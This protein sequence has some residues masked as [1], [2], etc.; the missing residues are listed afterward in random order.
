MGGGPK[1]MKSI[2]A[3]IHNVNYHFTVCF[4]DSIMQVRPTQTLSSP[5]VL[6]TGGRTSEGEPIAAKFQLWSLEIAATRRESLYGRI[7][8]RRGINY[9]LILIG[10]KSIISEYFQFAF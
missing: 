8:Q 9:H 3:L 1:Q 4:R 7:L 6:R 2:A 10:E 5:C